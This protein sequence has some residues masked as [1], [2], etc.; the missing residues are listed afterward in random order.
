MDSQKYIVCSTFKSNQIGNSKQKLAVIHDIKVKSIF[1]LYQI[2]GE[3]EDIYLTITSFKIWK[4]GGKIQII[5][6]WWHWK[7]WIWIWKDGTK[8][9]QFVYNNK[10]GTSW[11]WSWHQRKICRYQKEKDPKIEALH[12]N[13]KCHLGKIWKGNIGKIFSEMGFLMTRK[14]IICNLLNCN[15]RN[16]VMMSDRSIAESR[17]IFFIEDKP[18]SIFFSI[19]N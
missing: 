11:N 19:Q 10:W 3:N 15:L 8:F 4:N 2:L 18:L 16:F 13:S 7:I 17:I 1:F 12:S 5:L 14:K 9:S 6:T